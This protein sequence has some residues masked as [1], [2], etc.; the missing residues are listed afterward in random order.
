MCILLVCTVSLY[1]DGRCKK[2]KITRC[3]NICILCEAHVVC[4]AF[5]MI[6]SWNANWVSCEIRAEKECDVQF[7]KLLEIIFKSMKYLAIWDKFV[8]KR[9][10]HIVRTDALI[11]VPQRLTTVQG[12]YMD[13]NLIEPNCY[14]NTQLLLQQNAHFYY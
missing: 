6:T 1:Y 9:L 8:G 4:T 11:T 5:F 13:M 12:V 7:L 2:H 14:W 10:V 3:Y